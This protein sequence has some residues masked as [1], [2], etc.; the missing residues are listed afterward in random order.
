MSQSPPPTPDQLAFARRV[1]YWQKGS[2]PF[3]PT[4]EFKTTYGV[5]HEKASDLFDRKR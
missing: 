4:F 2:A 1:F 3:A 5:R